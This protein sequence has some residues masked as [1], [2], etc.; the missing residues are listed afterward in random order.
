MVV[1]EMLVEPTDNVVVLSAL[2]VVNT[3]MSEVDVVGLIYV[4]SSFQLLLFRNEEMYG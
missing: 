4:C 1:L 2:T 3:L